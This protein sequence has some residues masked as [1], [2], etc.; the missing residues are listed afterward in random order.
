MVAVVACLNS[1]S[2]VR[3]PEQK[4]T[5]IRYNC[6]RRDVCW[7]PPPPFLSRPLSDGLKL[8]M[9]MKQFGRCHLHSARGH[10]GSA[11]LSS[12]SDPSSS[13]PSSFLLVAFFHN[14]R[15][16]RLKSEWMA[17]VRGERGEAGRPPFPSSLPPSFN[18]QWGE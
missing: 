16:R 8:R 13:P 5:D 18:L 12:E 4:A 14:V 11:A 15:T 6:R 7:P 3:P 10:S 17:S 9:L 1:L 2:L